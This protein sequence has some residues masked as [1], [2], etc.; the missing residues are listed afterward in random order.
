MEKK[1]EHKKP[2][3]QQKIHKTG[4]GKTGASFTPVTATG[5]NMFGMLSQA[6]GGGAPETNPS[7]D[8]QGISAIYETSKT[9]D[10]F[11]A[12]DDQLKLL[13]K[14]IQKKDIS[15]KTKGL[16][17]LKSLLE[18]KT[19]EELGNIVGYFIYIYSKIV[20]NEHDRKIREAV[21]SILG[22]FI[23][24]TKKSLAEY[25]NNLLPF[26]YMSMCD[27]SQ[28]IVTLAKNNYDACFPKDRQTKVL[29]VSYEAFLEL[30]NEYLKAPKE[31]IL[32]DLGTI[33]D[34]EKEDVYERVISS[35]LK[36]VSHLFSLA[37]PDPTLK[38]NYAT[39]V[40]NMLKLEE[41]DSPLS[42]F[43]SGKFKSG[44]R[45]ACLEVVVSL[46]ENVKDTIIK[47]HEGKLS[48]FVLYSIGENNI[49]IQQ[50]LWSQAIIK[51]IKT[52]E[53]CW[54]YV[55]IKKAF[56]NKFYQCLRKAAFGAAPP[57]YQNLVVF[58]SLCPFLK[59]DPN[60][61]QEKQVEESPK[62][63]EIA[64]EIKKMSLEGEETKKKDKKSKKEKKDE[65]DSGKLSVQEQFEIIKEI[66]SNI[67]E[68]LS[69][70][71]TA[72]YADKLISSYFDCVLFMIWKRIIPFWQ[73]TTDEKLKEIA[74]STSLELL[75]MPMQI[76]DTGKNGPSL[77]QRI[78]DI[79]ASG[80]T[81]FI[82]NV[83]E[84]N[85]SEEFVSKLDHC[86]ISQLIELFMGRK[87]V[88]MEVHIN[89][90]HILCTKIEVKEKTGQ[91]LIDELKKLVLEFHG[92]L[93]KQIADDISQKSVTALTTQSL[94]EKLYLYCLMTYKFLCVTDQPILSIAYS[95]AS[96]SLPECDLLLSAT[97]SP[98]TDPE[99]IQ[100]CLL[101]V[102]AIFGATGT[103]FQ[104]LFDHLM[105]VFSQMGIDEKQKVNK[106]G[107]KLLNEYAVN[108]ISVTWD[109]EAKFIQKQSKRDRM[110]GKKKGDLGG[111][112]KLMNNSKMWLETICKVLT[113]ILNIKQGK[114]NMLKYK[115]LYSGLSEFYT[116]NLVTPQTKNK[117]NIDHKILAKL[118]AL[119]N[120]EIAKTDSLEKFKLIEELTISFILPSYIDS[121]NKSNELSIELDKLF[122]NLL[123]LL[124]NSLTFYDQQISQTPIWS[125]LKKI[126][127]SQNLDLKSTYYNYYIKIMQEKSILFLS[128]P[129]EDQEITKFIQFINA[130]I[131]STHSFK[132]EI[133]I[134]RDML[135][136]NLELTLKISSG[137]FAD[138]N[139]LRIFTELFLRG[140]VGA[141]VPNMLMTK[142]KDKYEYIS[143][144]AEILKS[145]FLPCTSKTVT[146][147]NQITLYTD[148]ELIPFFV[149]PHALISSEQ[150]I[151][152]TYSLITELEKLSST[153]KS[154][155][156]PLALEHLLNAIVQADKENHGVMPKEIFEKL[157]VNH[158]VPKID[159]IISPK[160]EEDERWYT[161]ALHILKCLDPIL[162]N[163]NS[164]SFNKYL[165]QIKSTGIELAKTQNYANL[166]NLLGIYSASL[167]E[168]EALDLEFHKNVLPVII[169]K[170]ST[171]SIF[172]QRKVINYV[173]RL[174][175]HS[176]KSGI[177]KLLQSSN[178]DSKD[179]VTLVFQ[180]IQTCEKEH[181][182]VPELIIPICDTISLFAVFPTYFAGINMELVISRLIEVTYLKCQEYRLR[183]E[184][185]PFNVYE[186]EYEM[187]ETIGG[188]LERCV[189]FVNQKVSEELLYSLLASNIESVQKAGYKMLRRVY[190]EFLPELAYPAT[191]KW[192]K[193][194]ITPVG[195]DIEMAEKSRYEGLNKNI[196][197]VLIEMI[198]RVPSLSG[199]YH[200]VLKEQKKSAATVE[201]IIENI[202]GEEGKDD[203]LALY[204]ETYGYLLCWNVILDK[205]YYG[206]MH[207]RKSKNEDYSAVLNSISVYLSENKA[208][209]EMFLI[210]LTAYLPQSSKNLG[211]L[212]NLKEED[213][214][215]FD[216]SK[217]TLTNPKDITKFALYCLFNFMKNY[218]SLTRAFFSQCDPVI[219]KMI[220]N[221]V[222][223]IISPTIWYAEASNLH[224]CQ[225]FFKG[226]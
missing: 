91:N 76:Y 86:I 21:N 65:I 150:K 123:I 207:S 172:L 148:M 222:T 42:K 28:E 141:A 93:R 138:L 226:G 119:L 133:E 71:E 98:Q 120:E 37:D 161:L 117:E 184:K 155:L 29:S 38:Q 8:G 211:F 205:V 34:T 20:A 60:N 167:N 26:W 56:L 173:S 88:I 153:H 116:M 25:I 165:N 68:A 203:E 144:T 180:G 159:S 163:A 152:F 72:M 149:T 111:L 193:E 145:L 12:L 156:Y 112:V 10:Q 191:E 15:T 77:Q 106:E 101:S 177:D 54:S 84:R 185:P 200:D 154:T 168:N 13:F 30:A 45:A 213:I 188:L 19:P 78:Y 52:C 125:L 202:E 164:E 204:P 124:Y 50:A 142:N 129:H 23:A 14:K 216:A 187:F 80:L 135:F 53:N 9:M 104:P 73:A 157:F 32:E 100:Y 75:K 209:Y 66:H 118:I 113:E 79:T 61:V 122:K 196:P 87:I 114:E 90:I 218:P 221:I 103:N 70:E 36:A 190:V 2:K 134:L 31:S 1:Q 58:L 44:I 176:I 92:F 82:N 49:R 48:E 96:S 18:T 208:V 102:S 194:T 62:V 128:I 5:G 40:V 201:A 206:W 224:N 195:E 17:E 210:Y 174:L 11:N 212:A 219:A 46:L 170:F 69:N 171:L 7:H 130:F 183:T 4:L 63:A 146:T 179:L 109:L 186:L 57:L 24:K 136:Q 41:S 217:V 85:L 107:A 199:V 64:K 47:V 139:R 27:P 160:S 105:Q 197:L 110:A 137:L 143:L 99:I 175:H 189:K 127:E 147:R 33:S 51:F 131:D 16:H 35:V 67:L 59:L 89:L 95:S 55:N 225:V 158:I 94:L 83:K 74:I 181:E 215:G 3:N 140:G 178:I 220:V 198:E 192:D 43:L 214:L 151:E 132:P 166:S 223:K 162:R 108:P 115:E 126:F 97:A 39:G 6:Y 22:I 182:I 81:H 169:A 121:L